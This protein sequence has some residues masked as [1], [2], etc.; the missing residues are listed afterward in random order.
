MLREKYNNHILITSGSIDK[1]ITDKLK[2]NLEAKDLQCVILDNTP[3]R[4][5]ASVITK[6]NLYITNDTG[7]LHVGGY[8]NAN[9]LALFGSTHGYEWAPERENVR[10]IQSPTDNVNDI[11]VEMVF[12]EACNFLDFILKKSPE[13]NG[14]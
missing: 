9:V 12:E 4:K 2:N 8:V 11:S 10:F 7:T 14:G 3:I 13:H 1:K 6:T 5:V